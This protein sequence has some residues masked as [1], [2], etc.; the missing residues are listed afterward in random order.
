M[1]VVAETLGVAR[2]NLVKQTK[3]QPSRSR[4][5]PPLSD[6]A[7]VEEIMAVIAPCPPMAIGGCRPLWRAERMS[8]AGLRPTISGFTG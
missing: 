7:V 4:G 6:A 8:K 3:P 1:R 2:S 5:R